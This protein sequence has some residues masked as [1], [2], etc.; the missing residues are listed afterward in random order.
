MKKLAPGLSFSATASLL[1]A[2]AW[3]LGAQAPETFYQLVQEDG[4]LEWATFWGFLLAGGWWA[5]VW[6]VMPR[7]F[8]RSLYLLALSLGCGLLAMEEISWGQ[9]LLLYQPP[10][11]F[12]ASN[13]QQELNLHNFAG[14]SLRKAVLLSLLLGFGVLWPLLGC[15][16][17]AGMWLR[18]IGLNAPALALAPG[19]LIAAG[20]YVWYPWH[21]TGELVELLA[22]L[23]FLSAAAEYPREE[24]TAS[25]P[26]A[27][28][29]LLLAGL[30]GGITPALTPTADEPARVQLARDEAEALAADFRTKRLRSRCGV[31]K[32]V[33]TFVEEYGSRRMQESE[34]AV[35]TDR[36]TAQRRTYFLDPWN[37][38]Y[39]IRH[40]CDGVQSVVFVYSFGPNRRRDSTANSLVEDDVG[41]Y[42]SH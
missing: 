13:F 32:R 35:G 8:W 9:R 41:A 27:G 11:T 33:F 34:F 23:G 30:L 16:G 28:F 36:Q 42:V 1:A 4:A 15:V 25:R 24:S 21:A 5:R 3:F 38:P 31:H 40:R 17:P 14:S 26:R 12:L 6:W 20:L 2:L 19:F 22:A 10:E 37:L 39:W 18:K 7:R 29:F